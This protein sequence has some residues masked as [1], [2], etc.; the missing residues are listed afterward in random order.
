MNT[1]VDAE[2]EPL[3]SLLKEE[4]RRK[5]W[6]KKYRK[7]KNYLHTVTIKPLDIRLS[8]WLSDTINIILSFNC[9]VTLFSLVQR[10]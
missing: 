10:V 4:A 7:V 9:K 3:P 6:S 5:G 2:T 8:Q 1:D